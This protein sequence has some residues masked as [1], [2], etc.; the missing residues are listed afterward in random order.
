ML[1]GGADKGA[2]FK[3]F[4]KEIKK[5]VKFLVLLDG[6][7]TSRLQEELVKI[8]FLE[9]KMQTVSSIKDAVALAKRKTEPG[10]VT[11]LSTACASFGMFKNYK[12]RGRLFKEEVG[13]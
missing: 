5:R 8:G 9:E 4:A 7:A 2:D 13:I 10:D 6:K 11:L 12:E 1:A 3:Q